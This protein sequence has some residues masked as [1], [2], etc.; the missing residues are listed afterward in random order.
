M[1]KTYIFLFA[2]L[3]LCFISLFICG[4]LKIYDIKNELNVEFIINNEIYERVTIDSGDKVKP[5]IIKERNGYIFKSW[6][7]NSDYSETWNFDNKVNTNIKL[8]AYWIPENENYI[9]INFSDGGQIVHSETIERGTCAHEFV[10][11]NNEGYNFNGWFLH[12][13]R[14]DF[15][16]V[17]QSDTTLTADW[18]INNYC[19]NFLVNGKI[20]KTC[21]FNIEKFYIDEPEVPKIKFYDGKWQEYS[22]ELKNIN[23]NAVYTPTVYNLNFIANGSIIHSTTYSITDKQHTVPNVP[24]LD[25]YNGAW[26]KYALTGGDIDVFAIYK[27]IKYKIIFSDGLKEHICEYDVQDC[28]IDTPLITEIGGYTAEW[29][30]YNLFDSEVIKVNA[31]YTPI[32]YHANFYADGVKVASIP[33]TVED[34]ELAEPKVPSKTGYIG[35]WEHYTLSNNDIAVNAVYEI[36]NYTATFTA[37]DKVVYTQQFN[38][39]NMTVTAPPL[40][41]K[42]GFISCWQD[43]TVTLNDFEVKA[44]FTPLGKD[45][46]V[47]SLSPKGSHYQITG[48]K[49]SD[50]HITLPQI[51]DGIPVKSIGDSAFFG[52]DIRSINISE[53]ITRIGKSTFQNC[54]SLTKVIFPDSLNTIGSSAFENCYALEYIDIPNNINQI[55][56]YAFKNSGLQSV[57]ISADTTNSLAFAECPYLETVEF[58][59][60]AEYIETRAFYN[61]QAIKT[62]SISSS[63]KIIE[64]YAFENCKNIHY[65]NF[66]NVSGWATAI[67]LTTNKQE[68]SD[69]LISD[70]KKFALQYSFII[71]NYLI[72]DLNETASKNY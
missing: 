70:G 35:K 17:L 29:E 42:E 46:F 22:L 39:N 60:G 44:L 63:V 36:E 4:S 57:T 27:K 40:V 59:Y 51:H 8:Y 14:F 25:G 19:V 21:T 48:Y 58:T 26:E 64:P 69:D 68:L 15:S 37:D 67:D 31:V 10:L 28:E 72:N 30:N 3:V 13:R 65:M 12:N 16:T 24:E 9:K 18:K 52:S 66:E 2:V 6:Y 38:I 41:L 23:V 71:G 33:Y 55:G 61:C 5:P 32:T 34:T 47:Y 54:V 43:Y 62:I 1:K 11:E 7:K 45:E 20:Y 53:G 49:G 50:S 56:K